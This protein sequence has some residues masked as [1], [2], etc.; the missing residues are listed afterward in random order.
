MPT[1][2]QRGVEAEWESELGF[3]REDFRQEGKRMDRGTRSETPPTLRAW[4][5]LRVFPYD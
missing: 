1:H 5:T 3:V 2:G 4:W